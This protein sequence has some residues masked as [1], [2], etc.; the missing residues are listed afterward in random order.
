M[1][2]ERAQGGM[3]KLRHGNIQKL[4]RPR[5]Y[6]YG[7]FIGGPSQDTQNIHI[8]GGGPEGYTRVFSFWVKLRATKR[9]LSKCSL[10]L[11]DICVKFHWYRLRIACLSMEYP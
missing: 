8:A 6:A 1:V 5:I 3:L 4:W 9:R 7:G 11:P 10:Y 2:Y